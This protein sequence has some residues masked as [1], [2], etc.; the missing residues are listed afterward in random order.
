MSDLI[1]GI[2]VLMAGIFSVLASAFNWDFFFNNYRARFFVKHFGRNGARIFY[3][4][5]GL[6]MFFLAY[7]LL[8][9]PG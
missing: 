4:A 7:K 2:L 6:F 1:I 3:T 5:L 9:V 8:T